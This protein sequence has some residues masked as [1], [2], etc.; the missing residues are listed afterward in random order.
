MKAK[1]MFNQKTPVSPPNRRLN[2]GCGDHPLEG[3][4]NLD[5]GPEFCAHG[6]DIYAT[7]PPLP[8]DDESLDEIF[9]GHFLEH[10]KPEDAITFLTE[11]RRVL[12][13]GGTLG[14]VVPDTREIMRRWIAGAIDEVEFPRGT[15]W[16]IADL[17]HVC[18]LFLYSTVQNSHHL[19]S[20]D[21]ETLKRRFEA[22]GFQVIKEI[23]RYSDP[24]LGT[25]QWYQCGWD[26]VKP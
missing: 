14:I 22:T 7:V 15:F 13:T 16:K 4:T 5:A 12:V 17:D 10:L 8:F 3:W 6:A 21:K 1:I 11:C 2:V 9:A 20:Y 24:R 19:W 23:N 26:A 25:S 18:S